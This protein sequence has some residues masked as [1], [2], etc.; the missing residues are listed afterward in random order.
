MRKTNFRQHYHFMI[1][2]FTHQQEK[3][4]NFSY[5]RLPVLIARARFINKENIIQNINSKWSQILVGMS[6]MVIEK[7]LLVLMLK[8]SIC[9]TWIQICFIFSKF[10]NVNQL[11]SYYFILSSF[12]LKYIFC[13][14]NNIPKIS[15]NCVDIYI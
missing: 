4:R 3:V 7:L 12:Y 10:M 1:Y 11:I 2:N 5:Q 15:R 13:I 14:K 8:I 6:I 9:T